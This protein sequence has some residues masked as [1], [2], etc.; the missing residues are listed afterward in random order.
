MWSHEVSGKIINISFFTM[1]MVTKL[2]RVVT[3]CKELPP[4]NSHDPSVRWSCEVASQFKSIISPLAE[5]PWKPSWVRCWLTA[6][7]YQS[8][9]SRMRS[10]NNFKNLHLHFYR[11]MATK[12]GRVL[13]LG[14]RFSTQMLKSPKSCLTLF[15]TRHILQ[16]TTFD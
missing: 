3:Y 8:S 7:V 9:V 4:I 6:R 14:R 2:V 12:L 1:L 11:L 16:Y 10:G 5:D 13:T 15:A